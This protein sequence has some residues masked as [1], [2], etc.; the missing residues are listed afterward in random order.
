VPTGL[1]GT[2]ATNEGELQRLPL[3]RMTPHLPGWRQPNV[4]SA[5]ALYHRLDLRR[6]AL[7][8]TR[9]RRWRRVS[10][11]SAVPREIVDLLAIDYAVLHAAAF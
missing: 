1:Q 5:I 6:R 10:C 2:E 11:S 4:A 8:H 9:A 3:A 7:R